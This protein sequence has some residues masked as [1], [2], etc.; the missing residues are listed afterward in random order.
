MKASR[1]F[2]KFPIVSCGKESQLKSDKPNHQTML[3]SEEK[4]R[5][6]TTYIFPLAKSTLANAADHQLNQF[7]FRVQ[8]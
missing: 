2:L 4:R 8:I 6:M 5:Q 1:S 3:A 7:D